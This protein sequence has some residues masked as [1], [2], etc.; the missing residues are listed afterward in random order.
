MVINM[1]GSL[2]V[3]F[4]NTA[5]CCGEQGQNGGIFIRDRSSANSGGF[6]PFSR[7]GPDLQGRRSRPCPPC[8]STTRLKDLTQSRAEP[9]FMTARGAFHPG[10]LASSV[11]GSGA[12][13][14]EET[15]P[16]P[17]TKGLS[18]G[19]IL[20]LNGYGCQHVVV[21]DTLRVRTR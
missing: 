7:M 17:A 4:V 20:Y 11:P 10:I 6:S 12:D 8:P 16:G 3:I 1:L 2:Y 14:S 18:V 15:G 5:I 9:P 19:I 21:T 13:E